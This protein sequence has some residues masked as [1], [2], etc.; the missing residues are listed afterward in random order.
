[1]LHAVEKGSGAQSGGSLPNRLLSEANNNTWAQLTRPDRQMLLKH[2][3]QTAVLW[4]FSSCALN[5]FP[6]SSHIHRTSNTMRRFKT[7]VL[8]TG[9]A[10]AAPKPQNG[11]V[12]T[13]GTDSLNSMPANFTL[14]SAEDSK[15]AAVNYAYHGEEGFVDLTVPDYNL[16]DNVPQDFWTRKYP[17]SKSVKKEDNLPFEILHCDGTWE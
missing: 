6:P 13:T 5:I 4:H 14:A 2:K 7:L 3:T 10:A 12:D 17:P 9:L 1:M 16:P 15:L 8:L 11:D